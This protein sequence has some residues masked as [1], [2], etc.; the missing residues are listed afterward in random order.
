MVVPR[1]SGNIR[2]YRIPVGAVYG[3]L[4]LLLVGT[5]STGTAILRSAEL[6][7]ARSEVSRLSE[8]NSTLSGKMDEM[9]GTLSG[10]SLQLAE[11]TS[12]EEKI[13]A[14]AD[15]EPTDEDVRRVGVGGPSIGS[16][17]D[18][19]TRGEAGPAGIL[20]REARLD[21]EI[22][23]RQTRLLHES[24]SEVLDA[25]ESRR[26]RLA[27]MPSIAPVEGACQTAGF[28]YRTDP[29]TGRQAMHQG[30]DLSTR[31]GEPIVA[32]ASGKVVATGTSGDLGLIVEIDHG[33]G[34]VTVYGHTQR[35]FVRAGQHVV[36]GQVIATV[37]SS[38]RSTNPH[39]HY[40]VRQNDRSVNPR[41]FIL[42]SDF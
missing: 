36:R 41:R 21:A 8:E 42:E 40:E 10:L 7:S 27:R 1:A 13:R 33:N 14:V 12:F 30:L 29:F 39:L 31:R 35:V 9:L 20:A 38:G 16:R 19:L 37:G 28:G 5:F 17:V 25:L 26:D 11:L 24:L 32:T 34:I 22:L 3:A 18:L 2:S 4:L 6:A 15:L 23:T